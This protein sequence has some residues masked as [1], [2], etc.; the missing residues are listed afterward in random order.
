MAAGD[1]DVDFRR[2]R[3]DAFLDL[4]DAQ[5]EGRQA[6]RKTGGDGRDGD[7][8]ARQRLDRRRHHLV[9]DADS[10]GGQRRQAERVEDI[11]AHGGAG[12]GA[13]AADAA[14]RVVTGQCRQV[15][16]RDRAGKPGGLVGFLD[17]PAA[18]QRGSAAFDG[19]GVGLHPCDPVEIERKPR[20]AVGM[21][22]RQLRGIVKMGGGLGHRGIRIG[23][24]ESVS[25]GAGY[26]KRV[27]RA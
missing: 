18:R 26:R 3:L 16:E 24:D 4:A 19:R 2:A 8:R 6:R 14:G 1:D 15:N 17:R 23:K 20:V 9:I 10:P 27:A 21:D 12:L 11:G 13:E 5:V 7:G 25:Q 22:L